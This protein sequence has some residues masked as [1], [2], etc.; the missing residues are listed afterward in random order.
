MRNKKQMNINDFVGYKTD[1]FEFRAGRPMPR[2]VSVRYN[3]NVVVCE[4]AQPP[5]VLPLF[6]S[7]YIRRVINALKEAGRVSF[8]CRLCRVSTP[9]QP[10]GSPRGHFPFLVVISLFVGIFFVI[11][12]RRLSRMQDR[13]YVLYI[14]LF[15]WRVCSLYLFRKYCRSS[16]DRAPT[17]T[18]LL[19]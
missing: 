10:S 19:R 5:S 14:V 16:C 3:W 15:F 2:V 12:G 11:I 17:N 8:F 4:R 9:W 13:T 7:G 18:L 1:V 6:G